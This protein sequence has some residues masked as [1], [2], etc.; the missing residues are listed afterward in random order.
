MAI[1][2]M[3]SQEF[4]SQYGYAPNVQVKAT[5]SAPVQPQG[6]GMLESIAK[7]PLERLVL[8]PGRRA[9]E[10]I[11]SLALSPFLNDQQK[12]RAAESTQQDRNIHVPL[13]GDFQT[14]GVK[15]GLQGAKQIA[16]ESL[17]TAAYLAPGAPKGAG[18]GAKVA[19]GAGTGY[20]FDVG[21]KLQE[22]APIGEALKPGL[23][24][25]AGAVLPLAGAALRKFPKKMEETNLRMTPVEK[26]NMA[27]SGKDIPQWM[28]E[29]KVVGSP[30]TRYAKVDAM[31]DNVEREVGRV[32][33]S[34][35]VTY[36]KQGIIDAL[37]KIPSRYADNLSEYDGVVS[38]MDKMIK[39]LTETR[40]DSISASTLNKIKRAEWK[41][42]YNK[43]GSQVINQVSDDVGHTLKDILDAS[44]P[45]LKKVNGEYGNIIAAR[46]QLFKA[47]SRPQ[48]GIVG[49]VLGTVA[50]T[51]IGGGVAGPLGAAGGAI[52][53]EQIAAKTLG[54]AT[55]SAAGAA[56]QGLVEAGSRIPSDPFQKGLILFLQNLLGG[57][58]RQYNPQQ[59]MS[60][61]KSSIVDNFVKGSMFDTNATP[62]A[63]DA[64]FKD[65]IGRIQPGGAVGAVENVG[66]KM[67]GGVAA[68]VLKRIHT[69]D[70]AVM[71]QFVNAVR[72]KVQLPEKIDVEAQNL[73]EKF[74]VNVNKT[75]NAIANAF[76]DILHGKRNVPSTIPQPRDGNERF[77][78]NK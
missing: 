9:G 5:A 19:T 2:R 72:N 38:K 73:M 39:T 8:E 29:K 24:T 58:K 40:G 6:R 53:G 34:S 1:K 27:K 20:G 28:T 36:P 48:T 26:Q 57:D 78:T 64:R 31:Y 54:T 75:P 49:K 67:I 18:L 7:R 76:E 32:V 25:A 12:Q 66:A 22:D 47:T 77:L 23:A 69:D 3:T 70:I 62:E 63:R 17:E 51:A 14:R 15:P 52:A 45:G 59:T 35:K 42:A 74:N 13:L 16:G 60:S 56:T 65:T 50:G 21:T 41:N 10:A 71:R 30:E 33:D 11:G 55:R 61:P 44:I 46:K 4:Q 68:S 43:Q 37:G